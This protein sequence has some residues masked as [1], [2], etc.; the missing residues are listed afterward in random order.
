[1]SKRAT[2]DK[3]LEAKREEIL[4]GAGCSELECGRHV[5]GRHVQADEFPRRPVIALSLS[6]CTRLNIED[7]IAD[8][9]HLVNIFIREFHADELILDCYHQFKAIEPVGTKVI[10]KVR[11]IRDALGSNVQTL[12][13]ERANL[14]RG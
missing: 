5:A 10:S 6:I 9:F 4:G 14:Y 7:E 3:L 2:L 1:M 11:F 8:D 13:D 12:G